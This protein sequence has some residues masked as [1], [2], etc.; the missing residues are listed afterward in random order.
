M[1]IVVL[2]AAG[3]LG[4]AIAREFELRGHEVVHCAR[5][6]T[7]VTLDLRFDLG[8]PRLEAIVQGADVVV[9]A[10]GLLIERD[11]NTWDM[12][13]RQA[14]QALATACEAQRV[15]RIIH[16]SSLG[17]GTG[18]PG[19]LMASK[20]E[21]EQVYEAYGVD[22]AVVRAGLLVDPASPSTRLFRL[23]ARMPVIAL[24]GVLLP[25]ASRIA[26]IQVADVA[27]CVVRIAEH[28]KA[29]RRVIELAGLQLMSYREMLEGYRA[30]QG[31][32]A[33]LWLPMPW[34]LMKLTARLAHWLPQKVFSIDTVRMLKAESLAQHNETARWLGREALPVLPIRPTAPIGAES[35]ANAPNRA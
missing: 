25:G 34:W 8:T 10:I 21:A 14:S 27:R 13:H 20:L 4:S 33:A 2:G 18:L 19:R 28:P 29:L 32:G 26:P 7:P 12:V 6:G 35:A 23:L 3:L 22:Y 16:L 30:A 24:P 1:K 11:G 15:A 17:T 31:K 5:R 9:N